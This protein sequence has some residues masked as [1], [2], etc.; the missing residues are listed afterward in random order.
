MLSHAFL[1]TIQL[2]KLSKLTVTPSHP[3]S[4]ARHSVKDAA[5]SRELATRPI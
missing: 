2:R 4:L 1:D 5:A 3:Q